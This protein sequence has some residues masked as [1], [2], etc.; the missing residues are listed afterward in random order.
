M[1]TEIIHENFVNMKS[2]IVYTI[3]DEA[4]MLATHSL[5]PI[6]KSFDKHAKIDVEIKDISLASR[7]LSS[8]PEYLNENQIVNDDLKDL[9]KLVQEKHSNIIKLPNISASIP[10]LQSTIKE[11]RNKGIKFDNYQ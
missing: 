2:K 8:F 9:G 10:Q 5:L 7:V 3:T 1:A 6:I 4:P 11:L